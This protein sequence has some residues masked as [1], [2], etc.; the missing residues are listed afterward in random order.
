MEPLCPSPTRFHPIGGQ[1]LCIEL[2]ARDMKLLGEML[3]GLKDRIGKGDGDFH[4]GRVS[5]RYDEAATQPL[6]NS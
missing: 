3:S 1:G 4:E 6:T 5:L 2:A